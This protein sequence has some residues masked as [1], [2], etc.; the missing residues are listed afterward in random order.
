MKRG[1]GT[2]AAL[3]IAAAFGWASGVARAA[4]WDMTSG[5]FHTHLMTVDGGFQLYIHDKATH[6]NVDTSKGKVTAT[7][8]AGGKSIAVPLT[9]RQAG[10]IAGSQP[11]TGDWVMLFRVAMPGVKP[12]QIRYSSK[13][14][15]GGQDAAEATAAKTATGAAKSGHDHSHH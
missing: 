15:P 8:L 7:L 13:M 14:K 2:L 10:V 4:Q 12:A 1:T 6:G 11:L 9:T 5:A 3:G